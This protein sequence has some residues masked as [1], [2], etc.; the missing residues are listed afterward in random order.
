MQ[1]FKNHLK[2]INRRIDWLEN[3]RGGKERLNSYDKAEV[4]AL[5]AAL[6]VANVYNDAR[7]PGGSHLENILYMVRDVLQE[8][9]EECDLDEETEGR[10][11]QAELKCTEAI[12]LVHRIRENAPERS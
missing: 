7:D 8:T 3:K 10:L 9:I 12:D 5:N 1:D 2:R 4:S 11:S 6:R